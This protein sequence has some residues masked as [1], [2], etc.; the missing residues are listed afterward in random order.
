M[1]VV[2]I[3]YPNFKDRLKEQFVDHQASLILKTEVQKAFK[4]KHEFKLMNLSRDLRN[5]KK[6]KK[7]TTNNLYFIFFENLSLIFSWVEL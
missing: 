6:G 5:I 1:F 4:Q 2:K 3:S 7:Q